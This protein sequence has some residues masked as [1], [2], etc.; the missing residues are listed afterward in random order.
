MKYLYTDAGP[1]LLC[2]DAVGVDL[3]AEQLGPGVVVAVHVARGARV[4][5]HAVSRGPAAPYHVLSRVT[6][7]VSRVTPPPLCCAGDLPGEDVEGL[8]GGEA[9]AAVGVGHRHRV[10][11]GRPELHIH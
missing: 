3:A 8:G 7:H 10:R 1:T 2:A 11:R 6:C 9:R 4:P 5:L